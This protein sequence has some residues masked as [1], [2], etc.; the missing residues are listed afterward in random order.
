MDS[1]D[2]AR[3]L[4]TLLRNLLVQEVRRSG[5]RLDVRALSGIFTYEGSVLTI[6]GYEL[7]YDNVGTMLTKEN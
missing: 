7:S 5:E 4:C 6:S 2:S 1:E 3:T